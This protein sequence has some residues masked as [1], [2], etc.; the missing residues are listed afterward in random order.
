MNNL[1]QY[2][3][4]VTAKRLSAVEADPKS[5]HQH[6]F[7]GVAGLV[8][9]FGRVEYGERIKF[10]TTFL[11]L[12]DQPDD[13]ERFSGELTWY[14]SRKEPRS[15]HRLYYHDSVV[16]ERFNEGDLAVFGKRRDDS[17]M[18]IVAKKDSSAEQQLL[19]LFSLSPEN[20]D[21][22][23]Y[24]DIHREEPELSFAGKLVLEEVGIDAVTP[25]ERF[26]EEMLGLFKGEFP[27]T[28][29][30]SEYARS[31][32][33]GIDLSNPDK[34]LITWITKEEELFRALEKHI[35]GNRLREGF[36]ETNDDVDSFIDFSLS[37]QNRRK[38]RMGRALENHLDFLFTQLR[39]KFSHGMATEGKKKPDFIFPGISQYHD[40][41]FPRNKLTLLGAKSSCKDRW[42]QVLAESKRIERKHL[43]T[44]EPGISEDQTN[45]MKSDNLQL[46]IPSDIHESYTSHQKSWLMNLKQFI[47]FVSANQ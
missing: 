27:I 13:A 37:V 14:E 25:D 17:V 20:L 19:W 47:E 38:A 41:S 24:I 6:E 22:V 5:S 28:K 3:K 30:F 43:I 35:V 36:G 21:H 16:T 31:K 33:E 18:L 1:F 11:Y 2:F 32:T 39:I 40:P 42:R 10:K 8:Q 46:V 4:G 29:I 15:E 7:N 9:L 23:D 45:E 34:I 26:L 12:G 44:L